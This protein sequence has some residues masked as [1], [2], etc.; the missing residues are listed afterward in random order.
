MLNYEILQKDVD[1]FQLIELTS[2]KYSG[3]IY[4][5]GK[6]EFEE[7]ENQLKLKFDY[8]IHD[9]YGINVI[10]EEFKQ[11][12]GN[13]LVDLIEQNLAKNSIV[14]SGGIDENR[15]KDS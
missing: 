7:M 4:S 12:I 6:V 3:I 13:I 10:Q 15:T 8:H 1:G 5:Y 11:E 9:D 14:Y 2:G